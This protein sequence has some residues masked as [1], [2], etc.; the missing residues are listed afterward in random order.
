MTLSA[1][2]PNKRLQQTSA[3]GRLYRLPLALAAEAPYLGGAGTGSVRPKVGRGDQWNCPR[4]PCYSR[5]F[6]LQVRLFCDGPP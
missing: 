1:R 5:P 2:Q 6:G 4:F 3:A